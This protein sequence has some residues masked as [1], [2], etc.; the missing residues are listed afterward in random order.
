MLAWVR[1]AWWENRHGDKEQAINLSHTEMWRLSAG[2]LRWYMTC[3]RM[4]RLLHTNKHNRTHGQ[5]THSHL[6]YRESR[7]SLSELTH[8]QQRNKC[9][10]KLTCMR[11]RTN[12]GTWFNHAPLT[13]PP[14]SNHG[15]QLARTNTGED[16]L[17]TSWDGEYC[18]ALMLQSTLAI[19]FLVCFQNILQTSAINP[20]VTMA[21]SL[22]QT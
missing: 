10:H 14:V 13:S 17:N 21:L 20:N 6:T 12:R 7:T 18:L 15:L 1:K 19:G 16:I 4:I 8:V 11:T 3:D 9:A 2:Y 5:N 22:K